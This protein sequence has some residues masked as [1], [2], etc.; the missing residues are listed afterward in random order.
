MRG[1]EKEKVLQFSEFRV[2]KKSGF[3]SCSDV[4]VNVLGQ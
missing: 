3:D 2:Q 1:R 4:T